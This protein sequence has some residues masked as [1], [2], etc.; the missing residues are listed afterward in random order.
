MPKSILF[1]DETGTI[2]VM[3]K[4]NHLMDPRISTGETSSIKGRP[5]WS[6]NVCKCFYTEAK[7][8]IVR[9]LT[10][11]IRATDTGGNGEEDAMGYEGPTGTET[12]TFPKQQVDPNK[13]APKKRKMDGYL[14][15]T[16]NDV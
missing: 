7:V 13:N 3:C 6:C 9:K 16:I 4:C 12:Q 5:F 1:Q 14:N 15:D 8:N 2:Y 10:G 11:I